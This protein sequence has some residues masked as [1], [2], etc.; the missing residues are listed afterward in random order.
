MRSTIA[1]VDELDTEF[2]THPPRPLFP[3]VQQS[4]SSQILLPPDTMHYNI[5][6]INSAWQNRV[7]LTINVGQIPSQQTNYPLKID[8][9]FPEL[10]GASEAEL[11]FAAADNK[12]L[13]YEIQKFDSLTGELLAW[14]KVPTIMDGDVISIYYD[15][16]DAVDN[17][18]P[19]AVWSEYLQVNHLN[20]TPND[21]SSNGN[22]L[23]VNGATPLAEQGYFL[24]GVDDDFEIPTPSGTWFDTH[25]VRIDFEK[26]INETGNLYQRDP[27]ASSFRDE[28]IVILGTGE[29]IYSANHDTTTG[30]FS[31]SA[32]ILSTGFHSVVI[33]VTSNTK[34]ELYLDG[35]FIG[36]ATSTEF[37]SIFDPDQEGYGVD[38]DFLDFKEKG[39]YLE[40][41]I[42]EIIK[43]S[44][45]RLADLVTTEWNNEDT[46]SFYSIG[47]GETR[48]PLIEKEYNEIIETMEYNT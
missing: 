14:V 25:S 37:N 15:N 1:P 9:T 8:S 26:I 24:D 47:A 16:D 13:D 41:N 29:L 35:V 33:N 21:S 12:Q 6:W 32:G 45:I 7:P 19:F 34:R 11:R 46:S 39:N 4:G 2:L 31:I 43:K 40:C 36:D 23:T 5:D 38:F 20:N 44:T 18:N 27:S 48:P 28:M 17:Q 42:F 30:D 3:N 10:I 22:D